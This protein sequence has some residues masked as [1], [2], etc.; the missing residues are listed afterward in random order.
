[1]GGIFVAEVARVPI[2]T[3]HEY[4]EMIKIESDD[5]PIGL[6][7]FLDKEVLEKDLLPDPCIIDYAKYLNT[8]L[9]FI[10]PIPLEDE[11]YEFY[12]VNNP[13]I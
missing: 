7:L 6:E 10:P 3:I 9:A 13:N 11:K 12:N 1:M 2:E 5:L 8:E 4:G